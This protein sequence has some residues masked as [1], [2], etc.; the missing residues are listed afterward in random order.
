VESA[1]ACSVNEI[2]TLAAVELKEIFT[3]LSKTADS[4]F[5]KE[6]ILWTQ[7]WKSMTATT[8]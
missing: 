1:F 7:F 8:H 4:R 5:S 2:L 3:L 6:T